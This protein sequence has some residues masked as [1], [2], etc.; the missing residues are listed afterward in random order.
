MPYYPRTFFFRKGHARIEF[1][2]FLFTICV[3]VIGA[4]FI[5]TKAQIL[6]RD[7]KRLIELGSITTALEFV[8]GNSQN[9]LFYPGCPLDAKDCVL[10]EFGSTSNPELDPK[11]IVTTPSDPIEGGN[12][13]KGL[14]YCYI[15][16]PEL[17]TGISGNNPCTAYTIKACLEN[18][19]AKI[20]S[21]KTFKTD[22]C[23]STVQYRINNPY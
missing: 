6:A 1:L 9:D 14:A 10:G 13:H 18:S 21:V 2:I 12:C 17:C 23:E 8:K 19:S 20:D 3:V 5:F 16:T 4:N 7:T 15:P 22:F 11:Y